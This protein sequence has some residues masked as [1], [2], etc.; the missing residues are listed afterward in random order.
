MA[1]DVIKG[2]RTRTFLLRADQIRSLKRRISRRIAAGEPPRETASP[3]TAYVAIASLVWTSVVRAKPHDAADEAYL[4]VTA[5]CRRR[6]RPPIDPGY[7]GNCVAACYAR[8]NVGALRRGGG[9]NGGD[10]E[11]SRAPRRR[12]GRRSASSW[13]TRSAATSRG[14]SSST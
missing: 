6:L 3:V 8:A 5:D 4:M 10:D 1:A 2:Q 12:S 11:G 13:R 9:D 7:F 14:G